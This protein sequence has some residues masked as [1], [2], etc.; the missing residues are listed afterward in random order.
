VVSQFISSARSIARLKPLIVSGGPG[1]M[2]Y[3]LELPRVLPAMTTA[4]IERLSAS[5]DGAVKAGDKILDLS[6]DLS[7]AFAQNCPPISYFR[8]VSRET[9]NLRKFLVGAGDSCE[10]GATLAIFSSEPDEPMDGP[11]TRSLRVSLAGILY[12]PGMWSDR[13]PD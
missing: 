4:L 8:I 7:A 2:L 12:Q 11:V 5:S 3:S 9:V 13:W 1:S 10:P 6:I